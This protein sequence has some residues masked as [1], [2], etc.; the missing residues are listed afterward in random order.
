MAVEEVE[1][2]EYDG[3]TVVD[4]KSDTKVVFIPS[5]PTKLEQKINPRPAIVLYGDVDIDDLKARAD[6][7][8]IVFVLPR[9]TEAETTEATWKFVYAG[10]KKINVKKHEIAIKTTGD[11]DAAQAVVDYIVDE[12][13]GDIEDAEKF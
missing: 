6:A 4:P 12:L 7:E 9:D 13:E 8:K 3:G 5:P 2:Y 10:A 11:I 1:V